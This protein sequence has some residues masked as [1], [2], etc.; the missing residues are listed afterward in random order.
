M[1]SN[2]TSFLEIGKKRLELTAFLLEDGIL[3]RHDPTGKRALIPFA[4]LLDAFDG[5]NKLDAYSFVM[6]KIEGE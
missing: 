6:S 3:F 2:L 1:T 4:D 5:G